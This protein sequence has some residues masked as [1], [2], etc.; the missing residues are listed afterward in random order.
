MQCCRCNGSGL[1]KNCSCVK[2][3]RACTDCLPG[4]NNK[5]CNRPSLN[6]NMP[7]LSASTAPSLS[8]DISTTSTTS[9]PPQTTAPESHNRLSAFQEKDGD[10]PQLTPTPLPTSLS[11]P[12]CLP[13]PR[14]KPVSKASFVWGMYECSAVVHQVDTTFD[15][16]V[17]WKRNLFKVPQGNAEKLFAQELSRL[18]S[19]FATALTMEALAL[20]AATLLPLLVLQ[21]RTEHP[22]Q[23]IMLFV[24]RDA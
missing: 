24:F 11:T 16:A 18:F 3:K 2:A 20:K 10:I 22:K 4:K 17:H 13:L 8:I 7:A 12:V 5:C 23:E 9:V 6:Q 21:S 15:E 19:A 1:C 14:Y